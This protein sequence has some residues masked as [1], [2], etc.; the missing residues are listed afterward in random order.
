[1]GSVQSIVR[2]IKTLKF[3]SAGAECYNKVIGCCCYQC[4]GHGRVPL[5]DMLLNYGTE[6]LTVIPDPF[7]LN[8]LNGM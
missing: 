5:K 2:R 8:L 3:N 1:M 4:D 7:N 6:K